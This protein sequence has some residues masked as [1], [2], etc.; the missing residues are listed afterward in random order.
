LNIHCTTGFAAAL[1]EAVQPTCCDKI[2]AGWANAGDA[3]TGQRSTD[4]E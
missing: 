3:G 2:V 4:A 1:L